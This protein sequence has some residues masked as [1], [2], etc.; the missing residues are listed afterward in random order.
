[1]L[2]IKKII[3]S[4]VSDNRVLVTLL[5]GSCGLVDIILRNVVI[6]ILV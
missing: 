3:G 1:M 5:D 2:Q 4:N 6:E